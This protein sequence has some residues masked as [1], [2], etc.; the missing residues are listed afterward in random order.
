ME[1]D[2]EFED[3][4]GSRDSTRPIRALL[5]GLDVLTTL[6]LHNGATVTEIAD[7][8]RLPRTTTYRILETLG[9]AGYVYRDE[10]DDRYRLTIQ[11]RGLSEGFDDEAWVTQIARPQLEALGRE[12]VWPVAIATLS[13]TSMM[14]RD[15]T[16][17]VS[18]LAVERYSPGYRVPL[19]TS[20]CG[21]AYLAWCA[22][23]QRET[24]IEILASS[25]RDE[26]R[27]ARDRVELERL[28][29]EVR[30]HGYASAQRP[31]R[32]ADQVAMSVPILVD[33]GVLAVVVV[34]FAAT[35]V[36]MPKAVERFVPKLRETAAK[37]RD[38]FLVQARTGRAGGNGHGNG[39]GSGNGSSGGKGNGRGH[40]NGQ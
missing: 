28:L 16:D 13:G 6:N 2:I 36:P 23:G 37:I 32:I 27:L 10:A 5:R 21:R 17:H 25:N 31:R 14:V 4:S 7:V 8:I 34:R 18:P 19:L 38:E 12:I 40:G 20:S 35:A 26:D 39:Q 30:A 24:L 9:T 15:T 33:E 22:P 1:L 11:V 29:G 3:N